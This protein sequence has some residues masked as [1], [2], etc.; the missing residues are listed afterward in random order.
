MVDYLASARES[1]SIARGRTY[2]DISGGDARHLEL[3]DG[4]EG[5][6]ELLKLFLDAEGERKKRVRTRERGT[7]RAH[8]ESRLD[9][10][11]GRRRG[12]V[13]RRREIM[14][15]GDDAR[16]APLALAATNLFFLLDLLLGG[17]LLQLGLGEELLDCVAASCC[18][19]GI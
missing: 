12:R 9:A 4:H 6:R 2:L 10:R 19:R 16:F 17:C 5:L 3:V 13:Q 15:N 18:E 8:V 7:P 11:H 1:A 14:T